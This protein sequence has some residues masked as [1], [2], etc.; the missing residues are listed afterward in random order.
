[1]N[2][3]SYNLHFS[4]C[5]PLSKQLIHSTSIAV[6]KTVCNTKIAKDFPFLVLKSYFRVTDYQEKGIICYTSFTRVNWERL[7]IVES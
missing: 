7:A 6:K 3:K 5:R 2:L 1:M 4:Y